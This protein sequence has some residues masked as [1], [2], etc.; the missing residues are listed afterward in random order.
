[1]AKPD[2]GT[3]E[4]FERMCDPTYAD[5]LGDQWGHRF[6]PLVFESEVKHRSPRNFSN[7]RV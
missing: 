6:V 1:M 4:W 7:I 5:S 2:C 3:K